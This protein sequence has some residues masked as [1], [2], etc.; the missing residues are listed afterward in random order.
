MKKKHLMEL[1][2][3]L[4]VEGINRAIRS[5][6]VVMDYG[7]E[8]A[9]E[10]ANDLLAGAMN[11]IVK[12]RHKMNI[13]L[14]HNNYTEKDKRIET[15]EEQLNHTLAIG[16][17]KSGALWV[18]QFATWEEAC[19]FG[20]RAQTA[21]LPDHEAYDIEWDYLQV[22]QTTVNQALFQLTG[23]SHESN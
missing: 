7:L 1:H 19:E 22:A 2:T 21:T 11:D 18:F 9:P 8:N 13:I 5:I 16:R 17:T 20:E 10:G 3:Q 4:G 23:E 15:T 14:Q 6:G 12:A